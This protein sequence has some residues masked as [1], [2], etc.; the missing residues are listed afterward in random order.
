MLPRYHW[1]LR[2]PATWEQRLTVERVALASTEGAGLLV[3]WDDRLT[4]LVTPVEDTFGELGAL[5][6][7]E[8]GLGACEPGPSGQSFGSLDSALRWIC[9]RHSEFPGA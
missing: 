4:A 9:S 1:A 6:F 8:F 2:S 7:L 5:W 3:Y